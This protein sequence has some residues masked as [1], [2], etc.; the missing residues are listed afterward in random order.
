M[1]STDISRGR[2]APAATDTRRQ[3]GENDFLKLIAVDLSPLE[4]R[5]ED[6]FSRLAA[7]EKHLSLNEPRQQVRDNA[8]T[9]PE[10]VPSDTANSEAQEGYQDTACSE[11]PSTP[12]SESGEAVEQNEEAETNDHLD[13]DPT[14][15]STDAGEG[16]EVPAIEKPK[17]KVYTDGITLAQEIE[18][19][20]AAQLRLKID[21]EVAHS[22]LQLEM[23][24]LRGDL[25]QGMAA[26]LQEFREEVMAASNASIK[27]LQ[28]QNWKLAQ[29]MSTTLSERQVAENRWKATFEDTIAAR[30]QDIWSG[31]HSTSRKLQENMQYLQAE[32]VTQEESSRDVNAVV[33]SIKVSNERLGRDTKKHAEMLADQEKDMEHLHGMCTQASVRLDE[34]DA[35]LTGQVGLIYHQME[36]ASTNVQH[37]I[38]AYDAFVAITDKTFTTL[39]S[40]LTACSSTI[41]A[42]QSSLHT[43]NT[44]IQ[45]HNDDL[46]RTDE[47]IATTDAKIG[48]IDGR[49]AL[50]EKKLTTAVGVMQ[51][52]YQERQQIVAA[53]EANL[54]QAALERTSMKHITSDL[55][56][57]VQ[58][59]QHKLHEVDKLAHTT[60]M[61]LNRTAAELPKM[62]A[63]VTTNSSNIAKNRQSIRDITTMIE[64]D[65]EVASALRS[66]FNKEVSDSVVRFTSAE[67]RDTQAQDA[68]A[69]AAI[70]AGHAKAELEARIHKNSNLIHQLNT[71]VDS[72]AIT[73]TTED[74]ED[75]MSTFALSCAQLGLKLEFF[76]RKASSVDSACIMKDDVKATLAVLLTKVIRFLGSGVSIEQNKY[77]LTAKRSQAVD[78]ITGQV[79]MEIP[80]QHIL[81]SFRIAKAAAF[82]A[83]TRTAMD[84]LEPVLRTNRTSIEFRDAFERKLKFVL[85]FGLANLFPNMGK[86]RNPLNR[87]GGEFGTCIACDRPIDSDDPQDDTED[88]EIPRR[89]R[90]QQEALG[91]SSSTIDTTPEQQRSTPQIQQDT[92]TSRP[93]S[94]AVRNRIDTKT[95][96]RGRSGG[97]NV[98][99]KT[100]GDSVHYAPGASEFVYRG[101]FRIP[102]ST[103]NAVMSASINSLLNLSLSSSTNLSVDKP[104]EE[105]LGNGPLDVENSCLEKVAL[106]G[107][108]QAVE[109]PSIASVSGAGNG[110]SAVRAARPHT[111]PL[112]MKSLPRLDVT[113]TSASV[114]ICAS[115]VDPHQTLDTSAEPLSG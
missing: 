43:F 9:I 20:R 82:S 15:T 4:L 60:E 63:L 35:K 107:K 96:I 54:N 40:D 55:G 68:I 5:F 108:H 57:C 106:L 87:R 75:K 14:D 100:N 2:Q 112:R 11:P 46:I 48:S 65:R 113:P 8:A 81:E 27:A 44:V 1:F 13:A 114:D 67:E 42:H 78:P 39:A 109:I 103:S 98:R 76:G 7:I 104:S 31:L 70:N 110:A 93:S 30:I 49:V 74:M 79:T 91:T 71:M 17:Q 85:E 105:L 29:T 45:R 38:Q 115:A 50:A 92:P 101:G 58:E 97:S 19:L 33:E 53:I 99:P 59:V 28:T 24:R 90:A 83:K 23:V 62:H 25:E 32:M 37:H 80:P 86:P 16:N 10:E 41:A 36:N 64:D 12:E 6:V 84:Q 56:F 22:M 89:H 102:K 3:D 34:Q 111:A 51:E 73:E 52:H 94:A 18:S 77:L 72:L 69:N 26:S 95:A 88:S 21:Q 61:A 66:E 47:R